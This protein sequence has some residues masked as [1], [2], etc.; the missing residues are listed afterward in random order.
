VLE[1]HTKAQCALRACNHNQQTSN[2]QA[3]NP[4]KRYQ[5]KG[6]D[7]FGRD[8]QRAVRLSEAYLRLAAH[9]RAGRPMLRPIS[10][11]HPYQGTPTSVRMRSGPS[12]S[13]KASS[14]W[15]RTSRLPA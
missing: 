1:K 4:R 15:L 12:A 5:A 14:A 8:V 10:A 2:Q 3:H 6:H 9:R 7:A 11:L 13:M